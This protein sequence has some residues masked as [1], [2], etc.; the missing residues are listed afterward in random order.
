[1]KAKFNFLG[2]KIEMEIEGA[3]I[4]FYFAALFSDKNKIEFDLIS[5][6]GNVV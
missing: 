4:K 6:D 2:L 5:F 1:M 3:P